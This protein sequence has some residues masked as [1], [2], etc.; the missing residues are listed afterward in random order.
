VVVLFDAQNEAAVGFHEI[1]DVGCVGAESIFGDDDR[2]IG[3]ILSEFEE[4]PSGG[5]ALTVVFGLSVLFADGLRRQGD[6]DLGVG[7]DD[8]G[9][10]GVSDHRVGTIRPMF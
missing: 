7:M 4:P 2:Q 3:M 1:S 6:D 8:G 10:Q 9:S 5:V